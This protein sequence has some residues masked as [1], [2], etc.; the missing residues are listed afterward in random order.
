MIRRYKYKQHQGMGQ[1][2][3]PLN[4]NPQQLFMQHRITDPVK[5]GEPVVAGEQV[6]AGERGEC[7]SV[8]AGGNLKKSGSPSGCHSCSVR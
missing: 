4:V 6:V 8:G 7:G 3:I 2:I 5:T 1:E